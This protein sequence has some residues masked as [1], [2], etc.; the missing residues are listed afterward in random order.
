MAGDAVAEFAYTY[1]TPPN[2]LERM[3]SD[4]EKGLLEEGKRYL[5]LRRLSNALAE[6]AEE[7]SS[8]ARGYLSS[9]DVESVVQRWR[10]ALPDVV[11][12][13]GRYLSAST[14]E[15]ISDAM[16]HLRVALV[17]EHWLSQAHSSLN[18]A[19]VRVEEALRKTNVMTPPPSILVEVDVGSASPQEIADILS[20]LSI[21]YRR[22]GGNGIDFS[23]QGVYVVAGDER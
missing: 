23:P 12:E 10:H 16:E 6:A 3:S 11:M 21:L 9:E 22:M 2:D 19:H 17:G 20:D 4:R 5:L 18:I 13:A 7:L 1:G 14:A 8:A 15:A